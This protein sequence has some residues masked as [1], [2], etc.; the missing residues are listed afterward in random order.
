MASHSTIPRHVSFWSRIMKT[1]TTLCVA[2]AVVI[3]TNL[4][5]D[6]QNYNRGNQF[7][8]GNQVHRGNQFNR[9]KSNQSRQNRGNQD[10]FRNARKQAHNWH[11]GKRPPKHDDPVITHPPTPRPPA[12]R[13]PR[14]PNDGLLFR[15]WTYEPV[16]VYI[17]KGNDQA[18]VFPFKE[19]RVEP[20]SK[21]SWVQADDGNRKGTR[22][23]VKAMKMHHVTV[24]A[25]EKLVGTSSVLNIYKN[26]WQVEN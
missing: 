20:G 12:T 10:R 21:A 3:G 17:Y 4:S 1:L 24:V 7:N 25:P 15:N 14:R 26:K 16:V 11:W 22:V 5:A 6:A 19:I 9:R 13:P 2:L 18:R 8:R 23:W